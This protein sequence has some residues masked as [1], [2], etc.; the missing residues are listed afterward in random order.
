MLIYWRPFKIK[1][2]RKRKTTALYMLNTL[3]RNRKRIHVTQAPLM[4]W[5][6]RL[7]NLISE[8]SR[9]AN[10]FLYHDKLVPLLRDG[11]REKTKK[12]VKKGATQKR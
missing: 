9:L 3:S 11:Q 2:G 7:D 6:K 5:L 8:P 4:G 12:K 1:K 10:N